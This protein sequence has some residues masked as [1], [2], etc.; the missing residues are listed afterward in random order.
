MFGVMEEKC[1]N[2]TVVENGIVKMI[3]LNIRQC[4]RLWREKVLNV[5]LVISEDNGLACD[6][7]L[8]IVIH[9]FFLH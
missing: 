7:R 1:I 9:M 5:F 2:A 3:S 6:V 8:V 4:A